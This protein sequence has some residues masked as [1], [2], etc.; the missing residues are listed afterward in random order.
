MKQL[1]TFL[2]PLSFFI[3]TFIFKTIKKFISN[4]KYSDRL[5]IPEKQNKFKINSATIKKICHVLK[6]GEKK[7]IVGL[8]IIIFLSSFAVLLNLYNKNTFA[9]PNKGG[10]LVEGVTGTPRYIN[11]IWAQ[12][13]EV[14]MDLVRLTF[15]SLFVFDANGNLT[16]DIAETYNLSEDKKIYT[17]KIKKNILWHDSE[18]LTS[19][20]DKYLTADDVLFTIKTIQNS[21]YKSPLRSN[22]ATIETEKIDDYEI[23]LSLKT[24]YQPFLQN[25]T[26]GI[27]PRHIW[28]Y[29]NADNA[30]LAEYNIKPVGSGP[31]K[32]NKITKEKTGIVTS[33]ELIANNR[34]Y[35]RPPF[36]E[37]INFKFYTNQ[38]DLLYA[39]KNGA[40]NATAYV[41]NENNAKIIEKNI[42]K[43]KLNTTQYFSVFFNQT[44]AKIL[45]D[46]NVRLAVNYATDKNQIIKEAIFGNGQISD[47]P[48]PP[49]F[50]EN[51]SQIKKYT[52]D[53]SLADSILQKS[54]WIMQEDKFRAQ[55]IKEKTKDPKT[56]KTIEI[57]KE[58]IPL[59]LEL[60]AGDTAEAKNIAEI[61]RLQWAKSGIR[62]NL[63]ILSRFDIEMAIKNRDY[64]AI[65]FGETLNIDPDPFVFWHS[66]K[67]E[68]PGLNLA[69][70][71]NKNADSFLED[72]R[73]EFNS[74]KKK[75]LLEK[76]QIAVFDD[77]P[78]VFLFSPYLNYLVADEIKNIGESVKITALRS[79]RFN[80]IGDWYIATKR[81]WG[82]K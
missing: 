48:L 32:F 12:T 36:I 58:K 6:P 73:Q 71:S 54:G 21:N 51:I 1:S 31:Y 59:Q 43:I 60:V 64:D 69:L 9:I 3:S 33:I 19:E 45:T 18:G 38:N 76:F 27:L 34:Y 70:F 62:V 23:K 29:L 25:L 56:K 44:N 24:P 79:D 28:K 20:S 4:L 49:I 78:A 39:L 80:G 11:P 42:K 10:T 57:V 81:V 40:I 55:E 2:F 22:L 67:T 77:A 17:I 68:D 26:F 47:Y 75:E 37:K 46:K 13:N 61:I 65:L 82:K 16:N 66:S 63:K 74:T 14:D 8:L 52:F 15:S 30:L 50:Q 41:A 35:K 5:S 72:Y 7:V 53:P